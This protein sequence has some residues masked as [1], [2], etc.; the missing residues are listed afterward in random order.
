MTIVEQIILGTL[1][2]YT[3][4]L[5]VLIW[6]TR[7]TRLEMR[8]TAVRSVYDRY[9][10]ITKMEVQ[11]PELHKMFMDSQTLEAL[12]KLPENEMRQRA[13]SMFVFD[14]FAMIFNLGER[15]SLLSRID[16]AVSQII[17]RGRIFRWWNRRVDASRSCAKLDYIAKKIIS[18]LIIKWWKRQV[19]ASRT[20]FDINEDYIRRVMSN[21]VVIRCWRDWKLGDTWKGSEYYDYIENLVEGFTAEQESIHDVTTAVGENEES[22][23]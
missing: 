16:R 14:Q 22:N 23:T 17:T 1:I 2:V 10:E 9:L 7:S 15:K 18:R 19:E 3:L 11:Y 4:T 5:L 8:K 13:L 20:L 6:Q 12:S 21:P